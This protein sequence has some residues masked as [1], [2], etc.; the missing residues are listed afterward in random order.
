M[1]EE[2]TIPP[3]TAGPAAEDIPPPA[4]LAPVSA[5]GELPPLESALPDTVAWRYRAVPLGWQEERLLLGMVLPAEEPDARE[6]LEGAAGRPIAVVA[7]PEENFER[8]FASLY[9]QS[10]LTPPT[11][12]PAPPSAPALGDR[13]AQLWTDS[14]V[15]DF[16][17]FMGILLAAALAITLLVLFGRFLMA[18]LLGAVRVLLNPAVIGL[19]LVMVGVLVFWLL[20]RRTEGNTH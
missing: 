5:D 7:L 6:A 11:L 9:P 19:L 17:E 4:P 18:G 13:L 10:V 12:R 20:R 15:R 16:A 14:P 3:A 2:D 8:L 1:P